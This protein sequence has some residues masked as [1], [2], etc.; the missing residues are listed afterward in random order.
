MNLADLQ[1]DYPR[2]T[3][4]DRSIAI[5]ELPG[6]VWGMSVLLIVLPLILYALLA[7]G[8][9]PGMDLNWH[10]LWMTLL[11]LVLH[12]GTHAVAW[13]YASRLPWRAFTFGIQW[14][15]VTPY[16][17]STTPMKVRAYRIGALMPLIV[18]GLLPWLLALY[19]GNDDLGVAA[20]IL[21][22]G[23]AG[24]LY[25]LWSIRDLSPSVLVQDH[26]ARAGCIVLYPLGVNP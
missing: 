26:D 20:S 21:I 7:P 4:E 2:H 9:L 1:L 24:D 12:E 25:I 11:L 8:P 14:K 5:Q 18:T 16:C 13:K 23:A 22:S 15:T 6:W 3:I 17:H 10:W 19:L